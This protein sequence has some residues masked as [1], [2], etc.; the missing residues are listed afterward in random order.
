MSEESKPYNRKK[1]KR[2][3]GTLIILA[4]LGC[5]L[6]LGA[7]FMIWPP[8][9]VAVTS[10]CMIIGGI[11]GAGHLSDEADKR[12]FADDSATEANDQ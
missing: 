6:F 7:L 9:G 10:I 4:V 1:F 5:V 3:L 12:G 8:L 11:F 2:A